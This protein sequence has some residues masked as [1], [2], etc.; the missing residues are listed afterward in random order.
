MAM[1]LLQINRNID[2][3][4]RQLEPWRKKTV[5]ADITMKLDYTKR[6][7]DKKEPIPPSSE[8]NSCIMFIV[9]AFTHYV[10]LNHVPHCNAYYA[11]TTLYEH[12]VAEFGLP[13]ILVTDNG[14]E[15]INYEIISL[16]RL[17]NIKHKHRTSHAPWTNGLDKGMNC[18]LQEKLRCIINRNDTKYSEWSADVKLFLFAY[19]SPITL[20]LAL[21]PSE[22]VFNQ[23]Q[24]NQKF[25]QQIPQ[26]IHNFFA[27]LL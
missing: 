25:S 18:S 2:A 16:C 1:E 27:N 9:D 10:S 5:K 7:F 13:E 24:G 15:F 4:I 23:E 12:L 26:K 3:V 6:S 14:T 19:K 22:M 20:N 8:G 21:S 17:Y 11:Y